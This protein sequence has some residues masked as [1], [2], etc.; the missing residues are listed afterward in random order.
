MKKT[1]EEGNFSF[2]VD[3]DILLQTGLTINQYFFLQL[4]D[5]N[6][7]DLYRFYIEQF[8]QPVNKADII[9]LIEKGLLVTK[10]GSARFTFE[11]LR[12]TLLYRDLFEKKVP[13][14]IAELEE[15]YPKKT[16][17]GRRLHSDAAKWKPKY[18][19]IVKGKPDLH[20]VI[21]KCIK[22]EAQHRKKNS[23]EEFWPLLTTYVNNR[24]WED[25][26]D[27]IEEFSEEDKFSKDI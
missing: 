23:N 13:N 5:K 14:A 9:Y 24:R 12:T 20:E 19:S 8:P 15:V 10:D 26:E 16:P 7:V 18:L 21:I 11:N 4:S 27:E 3:F 2:T 25:Y 22:A 1:N 6:N 17:S